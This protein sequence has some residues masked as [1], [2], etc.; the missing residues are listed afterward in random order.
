M[1]NEQD[2]LSNMQ[3]LLSDLNTRIRD[4][5]ERNRITRERTLLIGKNLVDARDDIAKE[6]K[7]LKQKNNDLQTE[8]EKLKKTTQG[9]VLETGKY[10]KREEIMLIERMLK[11][12]QPLEFVRMKDL[13]NLLKE[14]FKKK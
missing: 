4:A 6:L 8:L 11:D 3:Y 14:R 1:V 7:E 2:G 13:D 5:E 10:I 12:F 9:L